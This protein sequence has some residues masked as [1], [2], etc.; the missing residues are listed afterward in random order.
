MG[1]YGGSHTIEH[2]MRTAEIVRKAEPFKMWMARIATFRT[3][4]VKPSARNRLLKH[5]DD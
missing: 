5:I 4:E 2:L 3:E 1:Y